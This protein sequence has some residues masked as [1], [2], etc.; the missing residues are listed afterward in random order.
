MPRIDGPVVFHGRTTLVLRALEDPKWR[1]G[2]FFD[3]ACFQHRAYAAAYGDRLLNDDATTV[4]WEELLRKPRGPGRLVFLKPNDDLKRFTGT[5]IAL[6]QAP[7]LYKALRD[8]PHPVD[9]TAEVVVGIP[10]EIDAEW[11][12]FIVDGRV[13]TGSMYRPSGDPHVPREL[14]DFA[15]DTTSRWVPATVFVL[16][17]ARVESQWKVVECNCFNWSR[18]YSAD[19]ERLVR[20]VSEHQ[21]RRI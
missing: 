1:H 9:P 4:T 10:R 18:F 5:V 3:P 12:L 13:V 11:R 8:A 15:E 6:S 7:A 16:D 17:L 20:V 14:I 21:E 2:V 19:V